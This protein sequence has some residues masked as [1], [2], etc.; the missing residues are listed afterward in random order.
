MH[1]LLLAYI[2][3]A[4]ITFIDLMTDPEARETLARKAKQSRANAMIAVTIGFMCVGAI[5]PLTFAVMLLRAVR[6]ASR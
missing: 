1:P 6:R 5:W 4:V 3:G 2:I